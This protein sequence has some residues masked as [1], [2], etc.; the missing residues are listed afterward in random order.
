[1]RGICLFF[2]GVL[3]LILADCPKGSYG[4]NCTSLCTC[5][6]GASCNHVDG[7]CTCT[8][9]WMGRDCQERKTRLTGSLL[10]VCSTVHVSNYERK[11]CLLFVC[12]FIS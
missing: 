4:Q 9:G 6:N 12:L 5:Q 10:C 8:A 3:C 2:H 1:M 7:T 11:L